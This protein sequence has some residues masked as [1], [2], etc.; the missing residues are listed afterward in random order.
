M[1]R[2]YRSLVH[3]FCIVYMQFTYLLHHVCIT[4]PVFRTVIGMKSMNGTA[5]AVFYCIV[6]LA[7]RVYIENFKKHF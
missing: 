1:T 2:I 5:S 4:R 3:V 7:F 6:S